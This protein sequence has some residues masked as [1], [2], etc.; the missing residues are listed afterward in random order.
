MCFGR[1]FSHVKRRIV[2]GAGVWVRVVREFEGVRGVR[3]DEGE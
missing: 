2:V 3:E 1:A